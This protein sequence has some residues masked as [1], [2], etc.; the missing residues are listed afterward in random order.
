MMRTIT[1]ADLNILI[2]QCEE[3]NYKAQSAKDHNAIQIKKIQEVLAQSPEEDFTSDP[4]QTDY[5]LLKEKIEK[6]IEKGDFSEKAKQIIDDEIQT[7]LNFVYH[8][9]ETEL[10]E[11]SH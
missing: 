3:H 4:R 1:E 9:L 5:A 6:F 11:A 2:K 10:H 7:V 8:S